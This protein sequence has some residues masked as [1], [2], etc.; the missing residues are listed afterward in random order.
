MGAGSSRE[1]GWSATMA[2]LGRS[3]RG[4]CACA[5]NRV[6]A[7]MESAKKKQ[8]AVFP[9]RVA[10]HRKGTRSSMLKKEAARAPLRRIFTSRARAKIRPS[11]IAEEIWREKAP[12][13]KDALVYGKK[14]RGLILTSRSQQTLRSQ[15]TQ[16]SRLTSAPFG[17]RSKRVI[18]N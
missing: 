13:L 6:V 15:S 1:K 17:C 11:E 4:A 3:M 8:N 2:S 10:F 12:S 18:L 14:I 7:K 5:S 9:R 16:P